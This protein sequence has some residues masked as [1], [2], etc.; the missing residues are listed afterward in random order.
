MSP[1]PIK[2]LIE[3]ADRAINEED[4]DTVME[5]YCDDAVLVIEPGR[6]AVGKGQIRQAM[7][8]IAEHFEH[9]LDVKRVGWESG[10]TALVLATTCVSSA[11]QPLVER[12]ATYVFRKDESAQ[13]LCVID[14][15]YEHEV[16]DVDGAGSS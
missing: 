5:L 1:H 6:N 11:N 14:N 13:W 12:R 9:G 3:K 8:A 4:F 10:D 15:S 16:L 2:Q 7:E